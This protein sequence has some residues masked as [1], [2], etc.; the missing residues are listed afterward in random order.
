MTYITSIRLISASNHILNAEKDSA[1]F[2]GMALAYTCRRKKF[3]GR[4]FV[5]Q[6]GFN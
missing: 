6:L 5:E 4:V 2:D 3:P 1:F